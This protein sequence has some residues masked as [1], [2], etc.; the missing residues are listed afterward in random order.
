MSILATIMLTS[1]LLH[2]A[3]AVAEF[4]DRERNA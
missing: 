2:C 4:A 1:V 3:L